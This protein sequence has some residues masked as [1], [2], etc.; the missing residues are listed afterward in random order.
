[1][2]LRMVLIKM[3]MD[4]VHINACD[5]NLFRMRL[6]HRQRE[7]LVDKQTTG[8]DDDQQG[9]KYD[10]TATHDSRSSNQMRVIRL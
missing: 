10:G 6:Y 4:H 3:A 2:I 7:N 5:M 1:M 8:T 9:A